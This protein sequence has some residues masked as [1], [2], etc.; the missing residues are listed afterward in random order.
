MRHLRLYNKHDN[1]NHWL[2]CSVCHAKKDITAHNYEQKHDENNHWLECSVCHEKKDITA[3]TFEQKHD[4]ANHWL[5][6]SCGEKK[7]IVAHI[8]DNAC[9]TTCDTCGYVRT[10][11]HSYEQKHDETNHSNAAFATRKRTRRRTH[12]G[13]NLTRPITGMS[14]PAAL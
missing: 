6:C 14:V 8:F 2:E 1:T 12:S 9:D 13:R 11:T 10:I 7:D 3:H 5:E 4:D